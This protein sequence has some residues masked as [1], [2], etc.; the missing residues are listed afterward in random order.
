MEFNT[1]TKRIASAF[2][3]EDIDEIEPLASVAVD[4]KA[5]EKKTKKSKSKGTAKVGG[6]P[7]A[8]PLEDNPKIDPSTYEMVTS[9]EALND[10]I[11]KAQEAG[12]V[13][14]DTE[15]TSLDAMR[16]DLVGVSLSVTPGEACYI[17]VGHGQSG[18]LDLGAVEA[19]PEQ[20]A[21]KD[22]IKALKPMHKV[23]RVPGKPG[24]QQNWTGVIVTGHKRQAGKRRATPQF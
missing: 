17:P 2:E 12:I 14:F 18:E 20:L 24:K 19:G 1:L 15:T 5:A 23:L 3:I 4:K 16:A 10:W 9:E 8:T 6:S 22:V 21:L 11:N 13:A 7:G